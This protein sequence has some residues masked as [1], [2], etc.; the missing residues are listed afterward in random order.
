ML[1]GGPDFTGRMAMQQFPK[2]RKGRGAE[3]PEDERG[4]DALALHQR[5]PLQ[6]VAQC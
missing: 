3:T 2:G 1:P 6:A 5:G 4:E